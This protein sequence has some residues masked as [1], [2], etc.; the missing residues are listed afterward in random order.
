M[1]HILL[2]EDDRKL[3]LVLKKG[4]E[5]NHYTVEMAHEG[6]AGLHAALEKD[7]EALIIDVMLPGMDGFALVREL[8]T[9]KRATPV[10]MLTA[11]G[12]IEDRVKGIDH[13]ADDYLTKPFDFRELLARIRAILRRPPIVQDDVLRVADLEVDPASRRALRNGQRI[14][15]TGKEFELLEYLIRNRGRVLTRNMILN[16]VWNMDLDGGS[17]VA[18]VYI[19]YL[20]KKLDQDFEPKLIHTVRGVGYVLREQP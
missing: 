7:Y 2:I 17:N 11:R 13:G 5:E 18:D 6:R 20:R 9:R 19:N 8:R 10:L 1:A 4:L 15:L 12:S 16:R 3:A 14:D